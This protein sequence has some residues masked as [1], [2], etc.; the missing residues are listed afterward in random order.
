[1]WY[2]TVVYKQSQKIPL[3]LDS[4]GPHMSVILCLSSCI[5]DDIP[6]IVEEEKDARARR[7]ERKKRLK[8]MFDADYDDVDGGSKHYDELKKEVDQQTMVSAK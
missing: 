3:A 6:R 2:V 5:T 7:L 1:M 8:A 4:F